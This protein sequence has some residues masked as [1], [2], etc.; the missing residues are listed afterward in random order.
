MRIKF[1]YLFPIICFCALLIFQP[2]I[3][4]NDSI[5]IKPEEI[6]KQRVNGMIMGGSVLYAGSMTALNCL[7][8]KDYPKSNFHFINDNDEWLLNDKTGN[9]FN[10][11]YIGIGGYE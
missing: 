8:Y 7:W 11:Y 9:A 1:K 10:S 2:A 3:G 6:S 4:Q 5:R